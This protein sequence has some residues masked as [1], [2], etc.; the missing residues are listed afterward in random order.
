[1]CTSR[2][3]RLA[4]RLAS[5]QP[6]RRDGSFIPMKPLTVRL[7]DDAAL[8][9]ELVARVDGIP[10]AEAVR[11]AVLDY[12][13]GRQADPEFCARRTRLMAALGNLHLPDDPTPGVIA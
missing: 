12:V 2:S 9:L 6:C 7:D 5:L 10:V 3:F 8:T 1:M 4:R 13:Q 11:R